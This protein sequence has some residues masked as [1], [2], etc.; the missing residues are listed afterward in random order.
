MDAAAELLGYA[1]DEWD[2]AWAAPRPLMLI[3]VGGDW[4]KNTPKV[5]Y[6]YIRGIYS[7]FGKEANVENAHFA[8]EGH[9]YQ[10]SKRQ[11]MYPFMVTHLELDPAGVLDK[12]TGTFDE[13]GTRLQKTSEMRVFASRA[14]MPA[15]ALKPGSRVTLPR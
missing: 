9:G 13:T 1:P 10:V 8:T 12:A 4:T 3:S 7:Y 14:K 5:E 11:A 15:H 6:P 2:A